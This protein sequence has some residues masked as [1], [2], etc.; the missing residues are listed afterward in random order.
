MGWLSWLL[1]Q[2]DPVT[3]SIINDFELVVRG[4]AGL[5]QPHGDRVRVIDTEVNRAPQHRVDIALYDTFANNHVL[6]VEYDQILSSAMADRLVVYSWHVDLE[7]AKKAMDAGASGY[8]SKR[9]SV[10]ELVLALE[11]IH[12]GEAVVSE[13]YA[14]PEEVV[15]WPQG[16]WPGRAEGL[17]EREAEVL[18][19]I[20]QGL[21]NEEIKRHTY[22]SMNTVKTYIRHAYLKI[23]VSTRPHAVLWAVNHGLSQSAP[24]GGWEGNPK[25]SDRQE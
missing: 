10:D 12:G 20:A 14:S 24:D 4:L 3:L 2:P 23:E 6:D 15:E 5:L 11:Q 7:L 17:S 16:D 22:L 21:S 19:L 25:L 8:L 1:V 9:M 18:A 13:D